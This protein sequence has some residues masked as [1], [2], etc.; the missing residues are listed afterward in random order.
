M[1]ILSVLALLLATACQSDTAD[2]PTLTLCDQSAWASLIGQPAEAADVI[3]DPKRMIPPGTA[4]TKDYR[5]NRT[6]VDLDKTG[7]ITRI[8]CG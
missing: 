8:W 3:P 5:A 6:N 1:R 2:E 7:T 4:V